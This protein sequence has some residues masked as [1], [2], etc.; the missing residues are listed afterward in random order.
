MHTLFYIMTGITLGVSVLLS[1]L[2][3]FVGRNITNPAF[4]FQ[5][6]VFFV[7]SLFVAAYL[8]V[9]LLFSA[10]DNN[11]FEVLSIG[12]LLMIYF[13]FET[14]FF[15]FT[16]LFH[17]DYHKQKSY[18]I[19]L[20]AHVLVIALLAWWNMSKGDIHSYFSLTEFAV[21]ASRTNLHFSARLYLFVML[22]VNII[23]MAH[24]IYQIYRKYSHVVNELNINTYDNH[25][26]RMSGY[27]TFWGIGIIVLFIGQFSNSILFHIVLKFLLLALMVA[28]FAGHLKFRQ[29]II[30]YDIVDRKLKFKD[31]ER[32][33]EEWL[34]QEPFPLL[35]NN[36]TMDDVADTLN[37]SRDDLSSFLSDELGISFNGWLA[38]KR[39]TRCE[40]L[41]L[42]TDMT[43]SEVAYECG[44]ADL[45]TMSK[46]FKRKYGFPPSKFRVYKDA[47]KLMQMHENPMK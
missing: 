24:L 20:N 29:A 45:P 37:I 8:V 18:L 15:S 26:K 1:I 33:V 9:V 14:Y 6:V 38:E 47:K 31:L 36:I 17:A 3:F 2:L 32:N 44:Y 22:L 13:L 46:A 25:E 39:I 28:T 5:R 7:L 21:G 27:L 35:Q 41:L 4:R 16:A 12:S 43:L 42:N 34:Q 10:F 19:M 11:Q 30:K 40:Q 23:F